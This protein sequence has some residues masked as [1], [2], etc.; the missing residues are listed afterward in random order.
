MED[1]VLSVPGE[2]AGEF[3]ANGIDSQGYRRL[4]ALGELTGYREPKNFWTASP[5]TLRPIAEPTS[6]DVR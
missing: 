1:F 6:V 2:V 5:P 3:Y 4:V